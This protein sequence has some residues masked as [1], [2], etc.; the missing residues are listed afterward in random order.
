[1][2]TPKGTPYG[3]GALRRGFAAAGAL[4]CGAA[5]GLS[6]LAMHGLDGAAQQ[7]AAIAAAMLFLHG[8]TLAFLAPRQSSR[9]ELVALSAWLVGTLLFSGSLLASAF[10]GTGTSLAPTGG[11]LLMLAW[12]VQALAALRR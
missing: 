9:L 5:V 8:I 3:S 12:L 4:A 1:V 6:A 10:A 7:R 2:S 11:V